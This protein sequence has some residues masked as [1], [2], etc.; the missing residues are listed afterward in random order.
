VAAR[1][2]TAG[3]IPRASRPC[4][5]YLLFNNSFFFPANGRRAWQTEMFSQCSAL[6]CLA[7]RILRFAQDDKGIRVH[8]RPSAVSKSFSSPLPPLFHQSAIPALNS[9]FV[10]F[11]EF[12]YFVFKLLRFNL[13]NLRIQF[14][15]VLS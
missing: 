15:I 4:A 9:S 12:V 13:R 2:Q 10:Q 8:R 7:K 6:F 3:I 14:S 1:I 5:A 11:A